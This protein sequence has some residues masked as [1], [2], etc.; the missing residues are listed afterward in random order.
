[1]KAL[2]YLN[3][4]FLK[5]KFRLLIGV[6]ITI[7]SKILSLRIPR[8]IGDSFNVV[9]EYRKGV[10][11]NTDDVKY[12]LLINILLIIGITLVAGF[13]YIFNASNNNCYLSFD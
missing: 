1:M 8:Y 5:Y 10:V 7:L 4:Y 9:D 2:Q 6:F 12:Q 3:K 13:F 11:S